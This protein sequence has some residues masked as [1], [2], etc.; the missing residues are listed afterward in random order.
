MNAAADGGFL[1]A[2]ARDSAARV[3]AARGRESAAALGARAAGA[4]AA[5]R[6]ALDPAGFDLIAELKLRSPAHGALS[7]GPFFDPAVP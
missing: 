6:L 5:P 4:A 3:E 7:A 2:M 1:A